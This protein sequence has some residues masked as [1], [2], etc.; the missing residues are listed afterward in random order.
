MVEHLIGQNLSYLPLRNKYSS[1]KLPLGKKYRSHFEIIAL[2]LEAVKNGG[3]GRFSIMKHASVNCAQLEKFLGSLTEMGFIEIDAKES[4]V[5]CRATERGLAFLR[6]YYVLLGMLLTS[7]TGD[8]TPD[9][10][11]EAK[12]RH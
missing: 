5:R 6:Q 12:L 1:C 9:I 8:R 10:F 7:Q 4:R 11:C 3:E 2:I